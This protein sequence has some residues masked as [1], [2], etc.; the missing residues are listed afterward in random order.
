MDMKA[1]ATRTPGPYTA[2]TNSAEGNAVIYGKARVKGGRKQCVA[3]VW[4][5][6]VGS[7]D[8]AW[9]NARFIVKACNTHEPLVEAASA[10]QAWMDDYDMVG[11]NELPGD[12]RAALRKVLADARA[13]R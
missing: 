3:V 5:G 7:I 1:H 8:V 4:S 13:W 12:L 9:E 11:P 6:S 10:L 2:V